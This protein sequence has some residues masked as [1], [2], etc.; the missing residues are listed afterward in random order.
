MLNLVNKP[1]DGSDS[2]F[3]KINEYYQEVTGSFGLFNMLYETR[4]ATG[5]PADQVEALDWATAWS[6][7]KKHII[8]KM[9]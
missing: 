4:L 7:Y 5:L 2:S 1:K 3:I 8:N 6:Y 9:F